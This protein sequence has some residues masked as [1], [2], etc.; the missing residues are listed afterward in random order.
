L[1]IVSSVGVQ[2]GWCDR[3]WDTVLVEPQLYAGREGD[4]QKDKLK[5]GDSGNGERSE[6]TNPFDLKLL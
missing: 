1:P 3:Q 6:D 2:K 4:G 5:T